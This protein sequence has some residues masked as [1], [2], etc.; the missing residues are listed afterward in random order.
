MKKLTNHAN[1]KKR[2]TN[3]SVKT[4]A[5][6]TVGRKSPV[7][8]KFAIAGLAVL[9]IIALFAV[10][11]IHLNL[12]VSRMYKTASNTWRSTYYDIDDEVTGYICSDDGGIWVCHNGTHI[13]VGTNPVPAEPMWVTNGLKA[14]RNGNTDKQSLFAAQYEC[15]ENEN[16]NCNRRACAVLGTALFENAEAYT[17]DE[18]QAIEGSLILYLEGR[19]R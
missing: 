17:P 14:L 8:K 3:P 12:Q 19:L 4:T 13:E 5:T 6:T 18:L 7:A 16:N 2:P 1:P 10:W 9:V 15:N 11:A